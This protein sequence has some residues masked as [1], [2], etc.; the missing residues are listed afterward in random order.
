MKFCTLKPVARSREQNSTNLK[1][2]EE[3]KKNFYYEKDLTL[4]C[5]YFHYMTVQLIAKDK[6]V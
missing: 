6:A 5:F 1:G 3:A 2:R 4:F